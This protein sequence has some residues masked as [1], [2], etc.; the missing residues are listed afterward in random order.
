[1]QKTVDINN[2]ERK[3]I[4]ECFSKMVS[5]CLTIQAEL[6]ATKFIQACEKYN[7]RKSISLMQMI[8]VVLNSIENFKYRVDENSEVVLYDVVDMGYSVATEEGKFNLCISKHKDYAYCDMI[9]DIRRSKKRKTFHVEGGHRL[10]LFYMS[11]IPFLK[12]TG[13]TNPIK[14][15]HYDSIPIVICGDF[16]NGKLPI[17]IQAH[18]GFVDAYHMAKFLELLQRKMDG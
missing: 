13:V 1:M 18:H 2:W 5:P 10:D 6:D 14:G 8:S 16:S 17:S 15:N 3:D 7:I 4:Y 9:N 12:F 11:I